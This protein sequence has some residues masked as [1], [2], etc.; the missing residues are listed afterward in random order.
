MSTLAPLQIVPPPPVACRCLCGQFFTE[1]EWKRRPYRGLQECG[2]GKFLELRDCTCGSTLSI[3]SASRV[4]LT[5]T[6][7]LA[8]L[9]LPF[10]FAAA[11]AAM[12]LTGGGR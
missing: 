9:A 8:V 11:L 7:V 2:N 4:G 1:A 3:P 12:V 6:L 10:G 5:D